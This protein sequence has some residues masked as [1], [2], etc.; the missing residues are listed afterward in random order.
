MVILFVG[1]AEGV[2][3]VEEQAS[4]WAAL[5]PLSAELRGYGTQQAPDHAGGKGTFRYFTSWKSHG[6]YFI[7]LLHGWERNHLLDYST[8]T[9]YSWLNLISVCC[10]KGLWMLRKH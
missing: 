10:N 9:R 1:C 2:A 3:A 7:I 8:H 6:E 5:D 4:V